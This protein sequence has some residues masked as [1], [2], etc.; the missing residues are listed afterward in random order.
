MNLDLDK[1]IFDYCN[2]DNYTPDKVAPLLKRFHIEKGAP[3]AALANAHADC[4]N[5]NI[6]WANLYIQYIQQM[7]GIYIYPDIYIYL[8]I[9]PDIY[10]YIYVCVC[11][12]LC[13]CTHLYI[14]IYNKYIIYN[15]EFTGK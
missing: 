3:W 1:S 10:I 6:F 7:E 4:F 8:Y 12:C 14:Y 2:I 5:P 15:S 11:V 9:Y 13:V